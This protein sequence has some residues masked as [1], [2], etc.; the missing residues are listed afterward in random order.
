MS[1]YRPDL[2]ESPELKADGVQYYQELI[3][4]LRWT[5]EIGRVNILYEVSTMST[6]LAMPRI[7]H[8]EQLYH[9]FGY[10]KQNPKR[11]LAFDPDHPRVMRVVSRSMSGA[12]STETQKKRSPGTCLLQEAIRHRR[13]AS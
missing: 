3:G 10:L 8:L 1:V 9:V 4:V 12:T 6:L 7:G 11:K 2:D 13:I 5:V